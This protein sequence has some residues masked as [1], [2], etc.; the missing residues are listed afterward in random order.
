MFTKELSPKE[1]SIHI[2]AT[3]ET[4][5]RLV[6]DVIRHPEW[7]QNPLAIRHVEGPLEGPGA[8]FS[9]RAG[10]VARFAGTFKGRIRVRSARPPE[11]F[12]Y[13]THDDSGRYV[14][15][16]SIAREGNGCR[17]VHRVEKL[18]G[19]WILRVVQ[20]PIIWP[21]IGSHQVRVGLQ[22]IKRKAEGES[23]H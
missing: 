1:L 18:S 14:W 9:S 20:P 4:V 16:F 23:Y 8:T 21:L 7:S 5:Y 12:E 17:L 13:E 19:P 3:P 2:D 22:N 11:H 6:S 15:S 10:R